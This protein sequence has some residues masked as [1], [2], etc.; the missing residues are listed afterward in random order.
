VPAEAP[1][2]I[3]APAPLALEA[4]AAPEMHLHFHGVD[5][6]Q[7]AEILRRHQQAKQ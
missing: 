4:P 7:V 6:E 3:P 2:A 1:A 5:A